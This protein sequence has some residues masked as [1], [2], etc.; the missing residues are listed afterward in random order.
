MKSKIEATLI[1]LAE[2]SSNVSADTKRV[3]YP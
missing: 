1:L 3:S 2:L